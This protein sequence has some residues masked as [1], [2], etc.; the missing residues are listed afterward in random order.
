L[1]FQQGWRQEVTALREDRPVREKRR[2]PQARKAWIDLS[3]TPLPDDVKR[4]RMP[5]GGLK[6]DYVWADGFQALADITR[7]GEQV[8]AFVIK[9]YQKGRRADISPMQKDFFL[10]VGATFDMLSVMVPGVMTMKSFGM[11]AAL[12]AKVLRNETVSPADIM[13]MNSVFR[14]VMDL[15]ASPDGGSIM[16][17]EDGNVE[18]ITSKRALQDPERVTALYFQKV[19]DASSR[20][21]G[22]DTSSN[23]LAAVE[24]GTKGAVGAP[25]RPLPSYGE[26]VG[27]QG[28]TG[29]ELGPDARGGGRV[30]QLSEAIGQAAD[31]PDKRLTIGREG[32]G[33]M[34]PE[35]AQRQRGQVLEPQRTPPESS[36]A[37]SSGAIDKEGVAGVFVDTSHGFKDLPAPLDYALVDDIPLCLQPDE[38]ASYRWQ[39]LPLSWYRAAVMPEN[40][41]PLVA[42]AGPSWASA[43][44]GDASRASR[45][46]G[47]V[48]E[49]AIFTVDNRDYVTIDGH[50]YAVRNV[51]PFSLQ[52]YKPSDVSLPPLP[53]ENWNSAWRFK[54]LLSRHRSEIVQA[55]GGDGYIR[56]NNKKYLTVGNKV[57]QSQRARIYPMDQWQ[58]AHRGTP[59]LLP[60]A[61]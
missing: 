6:R 52:V 16:R 59:G 29:N 30:A 34:P 8:S 27:A 54:P 47:E 51:T 4:S 46:A 45:L 53:V 58:D 31:Q 33:D 32:A 49:H 9:L 7:P 19:F 40:A 24:E 3:T 10:T 20:S 44:T 41:E 15:R 11:A 14:N 48:T 43:G 57:M 2:L 17:T 61:L 50:A 13:N 25:L 26:S 42:Q 35:N 60:R 18:Q 5:S 12:V 21:A 28:E 36:R 55:P 38:R 1:R 39:Q 37:L 23:M 56:V 22:S